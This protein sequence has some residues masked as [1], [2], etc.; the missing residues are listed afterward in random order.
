MIDYSK[1]GKIGK[2]GS[3]GDR[4]IEVFLASQDPLGSRVLKD[5]LVTRD[6]CCSN[7]KTDNF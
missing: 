4:E 6:R 3:K 5:T 2:A 1:K 7:D